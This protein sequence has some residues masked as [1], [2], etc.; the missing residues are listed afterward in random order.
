[1]KRNLKL[2]KKTSVIIQKGII[3][4]LIQKSSIV[5]MDLWHFSTIPSFWEERFVRRL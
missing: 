1:M 4:S 5:L 3:Q 2:R